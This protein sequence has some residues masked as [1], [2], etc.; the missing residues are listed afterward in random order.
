MK[1]NPSEAHKKPSYSSNYSVPKG[2]DDFGV[3]QRGQY[4]KK[5]IDMSLKTF[6]RTEQTQEG[7]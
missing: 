3:N 2:S 4:P 6:S 5:P 7:K 1:G